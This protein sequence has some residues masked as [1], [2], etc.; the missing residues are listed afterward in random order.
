MH[1]TRYPL[2]QQRARTPAT[3]AR[4]VLE[5][6]QGRA[7]PRSLYLHVP[8]CYH[9]CHYCDFY[10][11]VD[12]QDRQPAFTDRMLREL[13]A[14]ARLAPQHPAPLDTIFVGGGTPTLLEPAHWQR[15]LARLHQRFAIDHDTEV[16]LECN[17]ETATAELFDILRA[18]GVNRLSIGAQ[19][20]DP[21]HLKTLER[22][23][24]PA[25]VARAIAL[26]RAAGIERVSIDL[27]FAVP[28]QTEADWRT[29]LARAL[30]LGTEHLSCY[31]L[32]YEPGTAMT[33]RRDR[34][35]FAPSDA[36]LEAHLYDVTVEVLAAA[37]LDRYEVSNF[38]RA[39]AEC[40]HNLAYWR[41][42]DWLAGGPSASGHIAGHRF[43]LAPRLDDY[44]SID[45]AGFAPLADHEPPDARR[46]LTERLMT[47][48]RLREGLDEASVGRGADAAS[49][50]GGD[51]LKAL[52]QRAIDR[53]WLMRNDIAGQ[54][55]ITPTHQGFLFAD[56]LARDLMDWTDA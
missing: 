35:Q 42:D 12:R 10:S 7:H 56:A 11:I 43:K 41:Q 25:N 13:D 9:K 47:G 44:L 27:I 51:R 14:L 40:R 18:G 55:R 6:L 5:P 30:D 3:T 31:A 26:A 4:A 19:S 23:H 48:V 38:A 16:T 29:D 34:G 28:G 2:T 22:W 49:P 54:T 36:D 39:G 8:F 50:G 17:P 37:G 20:F 45:D 33:A 21:R 46:A 15:L 24:D 1:D 32:T 53:Q 52:L